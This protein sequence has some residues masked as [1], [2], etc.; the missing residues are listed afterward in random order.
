M[1]SHFNVILKLVTYPLI[2]K[3]DY[4]QLKQN[5][6]KTLKCHSNMYNRYNSFYRTFYIIKKKKFAHKYK[7]EVHVD[8]AEIV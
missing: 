6:L 1:V 2:Q 8:I 7:I 3:K 5:T 4:N